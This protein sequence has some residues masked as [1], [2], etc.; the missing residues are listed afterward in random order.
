[1]NQQCKDCR[2]WER[3][4]GAGGNPLNVGSCHVGPPVSHDWPQKDADDWCGQ[5]QPINDERGIQ[6]KA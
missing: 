1:M 4:A 2:F 5:H 6:A 3:F